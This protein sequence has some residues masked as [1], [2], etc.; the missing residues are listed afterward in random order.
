LPHWLSDILDEEHP[1]LPWQPPAK[2]PTPHDIRDAIQRCDLTL[3]GRS[4]VA[5]ARL[6][7]AKLVMAFEPGSKL[8]GEETKLRMAVWLEACGDLN[9]ALWTDAT[10]QAIQTMKWMPKPAEFRALVSGQIDQARKRK[11]RL[12][13]MLDAVGKPAA[14]PFVRETDAERFRGMRDSFRKVG[15]LFK[16]AGYERDLARMEGRAPEA[17][18]TAEIVQPAPAAD[19][20]DPLYVPP[21]PSREAKMGL[22][23]ARIR[24][25]A[26]MG[27]ED[28][29]AQMERELAHPLARQA[30]DPADRFQGHALGAEIGD[31]LAPGVDRRLAHRLF[32]S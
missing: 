29:V 11:E 17:W 6:C 18:A 20:R 13:K 27:M 1:D 22:L 25:F 9:D 7:F 31:L 4:T 14:K 19:E 21:P 10:S 23:H 30:E 5:H 24:F 3:E 12:R 15:N 26:D 32:L 16:A 8:S 28:Y 2:L